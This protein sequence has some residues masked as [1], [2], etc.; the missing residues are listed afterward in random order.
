MSSID[1]LRLSEI[2]KLATIRGR[3]TRAL[4]EANAFHEKAVEKVDTGGVSGFDT[5]YGCH[6]SFHRD[7]SGPGIDLS[8]CYVGAKVAHAVQ[9]VL[10]EQ[11][12]K[13]DFALKQ[14]G[15]DPFH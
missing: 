5:C 9:E 6:V 7:G 2:N 14:L 11:R 1:L 15:I 3:L 12:A 8:G 10:E 13:V 4:A